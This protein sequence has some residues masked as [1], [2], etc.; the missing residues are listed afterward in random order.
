MPASCAASAYCRC[1]PGCWACCFFWAASPAPGR[2]KGGESR[3]APSECAGRRQCAI[4]AARRS[5]PK[6]TPAS[7]H[8]ATCHQAEDDQHHEDH[9]EDEK[10]DAGN[11]SLAAEIP[12]KPKKAAINETMRKISAH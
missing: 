7:S 8:P 5:S 9:K 6:P 2:A 3:N 1:S 11:V 4:T 10:Q 12:V